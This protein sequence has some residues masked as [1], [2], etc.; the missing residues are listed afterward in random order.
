M[1]A[2]R[3]AGLA[4]YQAARAA[5]TP[6]FPAD[7]LDDGERALDAIGARSVS[8][9]LLRI[10][11]TFVQDVRLTTDDNGAL[12]SLERRLRGGEQV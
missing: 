4:G 9:M 1:E 10:A 5:V 12:A 11:A 6:L 7:V 8:P 3:V 2:T